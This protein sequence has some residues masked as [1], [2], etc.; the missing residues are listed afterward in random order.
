MGHAFQDPTASFVDVTSGRPVWLPFPLGRP[1]SYI[2]LLRFTKLRT[3][4]YAFGVLI[5]G[6]VHDWWV[7]ANHT[8]PLL[9]SQGL[10]R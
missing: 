5:F 1:G 9:T 8:L 4:Q 6:S 2:S 10:D 3:S 7:A